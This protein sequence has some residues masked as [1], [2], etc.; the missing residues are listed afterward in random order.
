M[1]KVKRELRDW[2]RKDGKEA[3]QNLRR[4]ALHGE[5]D[6]VRVAATKLWIEYGFGKPSENPDGDTECERVAGAC[7]PRR[8]S[9]APNRLC[10]H[11]RQ[12]EWGAPCRRI[13]LFCPTAAMC[14]R[15]PRPRAAAPDCGTA[16]RRCRTRGQK[17]GGR[18]R[19]A[20]TK[21]KRD[22]RDWCRKIGARRHTAECAHVATVAKPL[23]QNETQPS[24]QGNHRWER[25]PI[26]FLTVGH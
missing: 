6:Y 3:Y 18:P 4:L 8:R 25:N 1:T 21:V 9:S 22:L 15:S 7:E 13:G 23:R 14:S 19:G 26:T 10:L 20:M 16:A 2:C 24:R 17:H 12:R 11:R 5:N